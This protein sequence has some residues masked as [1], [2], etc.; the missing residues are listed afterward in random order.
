[1]NSRLTSTQRTLLAHAHRHTEGQLSWFP[2]NLK[3]GAR[4]RTID[5]L[6]KRGLIAYNGKHWCLAPEGYAALGV[7]HKARLSIEALDRA[8][9]SATQAQPRT[10]AH[11]KQAQVLALLKRPEGATIAQICQLT[12]WQAH[13]VRGT[14]AGAFKKRLGLKIQSSKSR[15]AARIYR[16]L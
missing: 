9:T 12:G 16:I 5:G 11:S 2:D 8:I 4:Q 3:G 13:T 15:G 10:R 7:P 14:F 1:M 6:F